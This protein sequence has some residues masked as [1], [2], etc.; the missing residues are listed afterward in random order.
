[1]CVSVI[2]YVLMRKYTFIRQMRFRIHK[3]L[4]RTYQ[5]KLTTDVSTLNLSSL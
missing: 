1:M 5:M 4:N 3:H 2:M